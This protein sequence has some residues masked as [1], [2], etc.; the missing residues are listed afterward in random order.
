MPRYPQRSV[1]V[2]LFLF[3][4]VCANASAPIYRAKQAVPGKYVIILKQS[5]VEQG[6]VLTAANELTLHAGGRL[7]TT[8]KNGVR[9]FGFSGSEAA[10]SAIANDARVAWIEEDQIAHPSYSV[11]YYSDDSHWHLD[12]IDQ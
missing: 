5:A 2:A 6:G 11:E 9:G 3:S 7:L 12:R 1:C 10:V 8:F 4:A